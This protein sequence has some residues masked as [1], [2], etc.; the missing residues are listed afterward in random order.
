[1]MVAGVPGLH[2]GRC[3]YEALQHALAL[4]GVGHFRVELHAVEAFFLRWP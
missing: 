4:A 3:Q 1:M 2:A